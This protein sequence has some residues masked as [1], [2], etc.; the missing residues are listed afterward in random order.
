MHVR[1][2]PLATNLPMVAGAMLAFTLSTVAVPGGSAVACSGAPKAKVKT[3]GRLSKATVL[4]ADLARALALARKNNLLLRAA[5]ARIG[6]AKGDL[7]QASILLLSNPEIG[8]G[9]GPRFMTASRGRVAADIDAF[10]EQSFEL[11]GQRRHRLAGAKAG[12]HAVRASVA[13]AQ[14]VIELAVALLFYRALAARERIQLR[15]ESVKLA[16]DLLETTKKRTKL[17]AGNQLDLHA[18][19]LLHAEAR[20]KALTAVTAH[21]TLLVRLG[22]LCGLP[23]STTLRLQGAL[24]VSPGK[25]SGSSLVR[26]AL[27]V[28][29]DLKALGHQIS[30]A[31]AALKLAKASAW[32]DLALGVSYAREEGSNAVLFTLK[33][34]LPFFNRNQGHRDRALA[35]LRRARF[36]RSAAMLAVSAD[37]RLA[38]MTHRRTVQALKIYS[39]D[40]LTAQRASLKLLRRSFHEGKVG[41]VKVLIVQR[42]LIAGRDGHLQ[43]RLAHAESL[44]RLRAA[45]SL[46]QTKK[47]IRRGNP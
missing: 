39:N 29:P 40:V 2:A 17:G 45:A 14:R 30:G 18:S 27:R 8:V 5:R 46:P 21:R 43:A 12:L 38:L 19:R 25:F 24:P 37:V 34:S 28:R 13:D 16:G 33:V 15:R 47:S 23:A 7:F 36:T 3:S 1:R 26:R 9:M 35:T 22:T 41:Y 6:E 31:R 11:G 10:V 32:P 44:A 20:R 42:Q 4:R